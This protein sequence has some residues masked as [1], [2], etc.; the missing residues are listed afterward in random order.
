[1]HF[2]GSIDELL[3][4]LHNTLGDVVHPGVCAIIVGPKVSSVILSARDVKMAPFGQVDEISN[5][6]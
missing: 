2:V 6:G 4:I 5:A 1:M 3:C